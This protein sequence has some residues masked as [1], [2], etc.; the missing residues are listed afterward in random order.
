M[1]LWLPHP[2]F[3]FSNFTACLTAHWLTT[4]HS[5]PL[6]RSPNLILGPRR[7]S[8]IHSIAGIGITRASLALCLLFRPAPYHSP[9]TA[10]PLTIATRCLISLPSSSSS[11]TPIPRLTPFHHAI[12]ALVLLTPQLQL[13]GIKRRPLLFSPS[14][15]P[16]PR[17]QPRRLSFGLAAPP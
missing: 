16:R 15:R 7:T 14:P 9:K 4:T 12:P 11:S 17:P 13:N 6:Q 8:D 10:R 5:H 1:F 3:F 2:H